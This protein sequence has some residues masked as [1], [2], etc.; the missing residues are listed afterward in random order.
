MTEPKSVLVVGA[1]GH[2]GGAVALLLLEQGHRVRALTRNPESPGA[3]ALKDSGVEVVPADLEDGDSLARAF[4][5]VDSAFAM[6]TPF[7]A[8]PEAEVRQGENI[9][10]AAKAARIQHLVYSSVASADRSTAIPHFDSK[11][12]IERQIESAGVPYTIVAPVYFMENLFAPW[13]LPEL[14][15]GRLSMAL[16]A[17]RVLQ[18][19]AVPDIASFA[20]LALANPDRFLGERVDIAGDEVTGDEAAEILSQAAGRKIEYVEIPADQRA[21]MGDDVK[22]ML[23]WFDETGYDVDLATQRSEYP[24]VTWTSYRDWAQAQDWSVLDR[25]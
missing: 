21:A 13:T 23:D 16:P 22:R 8:G 6:A 3:V 24:E 15:S 20:V 7:E 19:I 4:E 11:A 5:G 10:A 2:Q 9:V 14:Q 1:T 18:Q 12:E 17:D 25:G